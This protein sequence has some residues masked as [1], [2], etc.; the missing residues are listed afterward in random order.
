MKCLVHFESSSIK[1]LLLKKLLTNLQKCNI[2]EVYLSFKKIRSNIEYKYQQ[3]IT[4][5]KYQD[6]VWINQIQ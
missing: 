3:L 4:L 2:Q 5:L 1:K 6:E